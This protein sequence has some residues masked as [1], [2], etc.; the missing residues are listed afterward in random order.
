MSRN[1]HCWRRRYRP[2]IEIRYRVA[3]GVRHGRPI[4]D[5][6]PLIGS[7]AVVVYGYHWSRVCR[8]ECET[9]PTAP[10]GAIEGPYVHRLAA[11][12]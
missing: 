2:K 4:Y 9:V 5:L 8:V 7:Q 3:V 1:I 10:S 6:C 12:G 11:S